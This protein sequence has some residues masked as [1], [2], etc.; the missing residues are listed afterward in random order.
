M[1]AHGHHL[2][3]CPTEQDTEIAAQGSRLLATILGQG[4]T[5]RLRLVD[6]DRDFIVP[7]GAI[8][9][10]CQILDYMSKGNEVSVVPIYSELTTQQAADFLNVS[11]P[12]L[13]KLLEAGAIP[14]R[15]V[16]KHRRILF[17]NLM[18]YRDKKLAESHAALD[19][20]TAQAQELGMGY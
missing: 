14:F 19:E 18:A 20:L 11:R 2:I 7:T 16:G 15:K 5:G 9:M 4:E 8:R 6:G 10:L 12:F 1:V 13:V 3:E 17:E